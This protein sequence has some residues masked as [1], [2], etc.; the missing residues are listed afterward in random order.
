MSLLTKAIWGDDSELRD[1]DIPTAHPLSEFL[2]HRER[3]LVRK[4]LPGIADA[5]WEESLEA[6]PVE[7]AEESDRVWRAAYAARRVKEWLP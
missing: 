4:G 3:E 7:K 1:R 5:S 2:S 6:A